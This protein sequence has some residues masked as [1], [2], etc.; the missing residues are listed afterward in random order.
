MDSFY[1]GLR[2]NFLRLKSG[3]SAAYLPLI[4]VLFEYYLFKGYVGEWQRDSYIYA[5]CWISLQFLTS[6][7][8]WLWL[9]FVYFQII[10]LHDV[11][12]S[13]RDATEMSCLQRFFSKKTSVHI[14]H[15]VSMRNKRRRLRGQSAEGGGTAEEENGPKGGYMKHHAEIIHINGL[16]STTSSIFFGLC[17]LDSWLFFTLDPMVLAVLFFLVLARIYSCVYLTRLT[18]QVYNHESF[19]FVNHIH[20]Y[21]MKNVDLA[22]DRVLLFEVVKASRVKSGARISL[23]NWC[24]GFLILIGWIFWDGNSFTVHPEPFVD[25]LLASRPYSFERQELFSQPIVG[26][27]P[28]WLTGDG[29]FPVENFY[30]LVSF[31]ARELFPWPG[32]CAAANHYSSL[33]TPE[34]VEDAWGGASS[35]TAEYAVRPEDGCSVNT[36]ALGQVVPWWLLA[37]DEHLSPE[38][39][40]FYGFGE[41]LELPVQHERFSIPSRRMRFFTQQGLATWFL[42]TAPGLS[43]E[44]RKDSDVGASDLLRGWNGSASARCEAVGVPHNAVFGVEDGGLGGGSAPESRVPAPRD[45]P[46]LRLGAYVQDACVEAWRSCLRRRLSAT[47]GVYATAGGAAD[48]CYSEGCFQRTFDVTYPPAGSPVVISAAAGGARGDSYYSQAQG[49]TQEAEYLPADVHFFAAREWL[50]FVTGSGAP[51]LN[52]T[53]PWPWLSPEV[54]LPVAEAQAALPSGPSRFLTDRRAFLFLPALSRKPRGPRKSDTYSSK[55]VNF[56]RLLGSLWTERSY[57]GYASAGIDSSR[58][59]TKFVDADIPDD[60]G[61]VCGIRG[62]RVEYAFEEDFFLLPHVMGGTNASGEL[63]DSSYRNS[64]RRANALM[65]PVVQKGRS[66]RQ[67]TAGLPSCFLV[68]LFQFLRAGGCSRG[69]VHDIG[70][71]TCLMETRPRSIAVL[72][73][74]SFVLE[75]ATLGAQ[76][77][78]GQPL[79]ITRAHLDAWWAHLAH[80]VFILRHELLEQKTTHLFRTG[81]E[82]REL[83]VAVQL[84]ADYQPYGPDLQPITQV[85]FAGAAAAENTTKYLFSLYKNGPPPPSTAVEILAKQLSEWHS[86]R[87]RLDVL[88]ALQNLMITIFWSFLILYPVIYSTEYNGYAN[89]RLGFF[90]NFRLGF[91]SR[92]GAEETKRNYPFAPKEGFFMNMDFYQVEEPENSSDADS[93]RIKFERMLG[94]T[95]ILSFLKVLYHWKKNNKNL[96][97]LNH[98]FGQALKEA[99]KE[100]KRHKESVKMLRTTKREAKLF[101][102]ERHEHSDEERE[103]L[104]DEATSSDEEEEDDA[105]RLLP[106]NSKKIFFRGGTRLLVPFTRTYVRQ[107]PGEDRPEALEIKMSATGALAL[108]VLVNRAAWLH[109]F[110]LLAASICFSTLISYGSWLLYSGRTAVSWFETSV[111]FIY[112]DRSPLVVLLFWWAVNFCASLLTYVALRKLMTN[113]F[114]VFFD[115]DVW[116]P[117]L[118]KYILSEFFY[119]HPSLHQAFCSCSPPRQPAGPESPPKRSRRRHRGVCC[120]NCASLTLLTRPDLVYSAKPR[121]GTIADSS[122]ITTADFQFIT[123]HPQLVLRLFLDKVSQGLFGQEQKSIL[124]FYRCVFALHEWVWF[125]LFVILTWFSQVATY[126]PYPASYAIWGNPR[127][128]DSILF[129]SAFLVCVLLPIGFC[130]FHSITRPPHRTLQKTID[131]I[132]R[133]TDQRAVIP[134][135]GDAAGYDFPVAGTD[136]NLDDRNWFLE[137]VHGLDAYQKKFIFDYYIGSYVFLSWYGT[138]PTAKGR[139]CATEDHEVEPSSFF[140]EDEDILWGHF[141]KKMCR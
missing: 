98:A 25:E 28:A 72:K 65:A 119:E 97:V 85:T 139:P 107:N 62:P 41:C 106:K 126:S 40:D 1:V 131:V 117:F 102:N 84:S 138:K 136:V 38:L 45:G 82:A 39:L 88:F 44:G 32:A 135:R 132:R 71:A 54:T 77:G 13:L 140:F 53:G 90:Q 124:F 108:H 80:V 112:P 7:L 22:V 91:R 3:H 56:T 133:R 127:D 87:D 23:L 36:S 19:K 93:T 17:F 94:G 100:R 113:Y 110:C 120:D 6:I 59:R 128:W 43:Y 61:L 12:F 89:W 67:A 78:S 16:F 96:D 92:A 130:V 99:R 81:R 34:A 11:E 18:Q 109:S 37:E 114:P 15:H 21:H 48:D 57:L 103:Q 50:R 122:D 104:R 35:G 121:P 49:F 47:G 58:K 46:Y 64:A 118:Y 70:A 66:V 33:R 26:G 14:R 83:F 52:L 4:L 101:V 105:E 24:V 2:V 79:V 129:S 116:R 8:F 68:H 30:G 9:E 29:T 42:R 111:Q 27:A 134:E 51:V 115:R 20:L 123:K 137:K 5:I 86:V 141:F 60:I 74:L 75:N 69:L 76:Q 63:L 55:P 31:D 95:S 125:S 10:F 73:K